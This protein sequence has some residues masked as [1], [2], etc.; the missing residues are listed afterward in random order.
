MPGDTEPN[1]PHPD[2][3][4]SA[5]ASRCPPFLLSCALP[6]ARSSQH[7]RSLPHCFYPL[8]RLLTLRP[9]RRRRLAKS[10]VG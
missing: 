3:Q 4:R 1:S 6:T 10:M 9:D 2:D 7:K 8:R 5:A